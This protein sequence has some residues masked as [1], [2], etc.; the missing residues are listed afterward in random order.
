MCDQNRNLVFGVVAAVVNIGVPPA[1]L[2]AG[3]IGGLEVIAVTVVGSVC[4]FGCTYAALGETFGLLERRRRR[5][6]G[7]AGLALGAGGGAL[8]LDQQ[9]RRQVLVQL[10][11]ADVADLEQR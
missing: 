6:R 2:V 3:G 10:L 1:Q 5:R 11:A 8:A 7:V 9:R 4:G